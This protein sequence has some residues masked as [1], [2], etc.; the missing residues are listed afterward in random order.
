ML[1]AVEGDTPPLLPPLPPR[2]HRRIR[3]R[4]GGLE[5]PARHH[6]ERPQA[7]YS[8][9]HFGERSCEGTER[10]DGANVEREGDA[11]TIAKNLLIWQAAFEA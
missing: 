7:L 6:P 8:L 2:R 9:D 10:E 4:R 5:D 3:R 1:L 11:R